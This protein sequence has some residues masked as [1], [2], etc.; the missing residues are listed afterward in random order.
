MPEDDPLPR[1]NRRSALAAIGTGAGSVVGI[2]A[3]S[4]RAVAWDRFDAV[5]VGAERCG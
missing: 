5:S 4:Q 1:V 3:L 2:D